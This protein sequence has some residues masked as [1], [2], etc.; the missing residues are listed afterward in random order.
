SRKIGAKAL[1]ILPQD[2]GGTFT[3]T[4]EP[5]LDAD[6]PQAL[7]DAQI[8]TLAA[9]GQRIAQHYGAP[10]DV[11]W[12]LRKNEFTIL[13][14]RPITSLYPLPDLP[15]TP[16]NERIYFSFNAGQGVPDPFTPLGIAAL[17]LLARGTGFKRSPQE[18]L[19]VA[20]KRLFI[21]VTDVA[22]D[23]RLKHILLAGL[24]RADPAARQTVIALMQTGRITTHHTLTFAYARAISGGVRMLIARVLRNMRE[25]DSAQARALTYADAYFTQTRDHVRATQTLAELLRVMETDLPRMIGAMMAHM[26]PAILPAFAGMALVDEWLTKWLGLPKGSGLVFMRALRGNVTAEMSLKLWDAA[27][28]IRAD[29]SARE[30]MLNA[31][32][33]HL[34]ADYRSGALPATAQNA[35]AKFLDEYGMRAV[36]EIDMGRERWREDPTSILQTLHGYLQLDDPKLAPDVLYEQGAREADHLR[37]EYV[38]RVRRTPFGAVRAKLLGAMIHRMRTLGGLRETPKFYG[39]KTFDLFRTALLEHGRALVTQSQLNQTDDI[40]FVPF[41]DLQN[42]AR[43]QE[44]DL[45]TIVAAQRADYERERG[46]RQLPRVLM[47]TGEVFYGGMKSANPNDLVGDGVSPGVAEGIVRVVLDP[48]GVRL[49]PGEILVCPATDPGWT[50]LFL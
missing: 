41:D 11:E 39:I 14:A 19:A 18:F 50:P 42:V 1:A 40:F 26:L 43:G 46:R 17:H 27:Q 49:A 24:A 36:A 45:K 32:V 15:Y 28:T 13:Q 29:D 10:Q 25:P 16:D 38:A 2:G 6:E 44:V 30:R 9:I 7:T 3:V 8:L 34:V 31:S 5:H 22:R 37:D 23:P 20:G 21:D 12:A 48:R 35:I 33:E 47:S 4:A